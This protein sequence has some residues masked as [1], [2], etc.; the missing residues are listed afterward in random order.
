M[1]S[2]PFRKLLPYV[3]R[4]GCMSCLKC[5]SPT[6]IYTAHAPYSPSCVLL[7]SSVKL[8]V[9]TWFPM[10]SECHCTIF[11]TFLYFHQSNSYHIAQQIFCHSV[12]YLALQPEGN[13]QKGKGFCPLQATSRS[14]C[15]DSAERIVYFRCNE[16]VGSEPFMRLCFKLVGAFLKH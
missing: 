12:P 14:L 10:I 15:Y 11:F 9:T 4:I 1:P 16:W 7:I 8:P 2:L 13:V 5:S 6:A 3:F